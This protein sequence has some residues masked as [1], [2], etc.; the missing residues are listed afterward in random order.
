MYLSL[1]KPPA[2]IPTFSK[3]LFQMQTFHPESVKVFYDVKGHQ[4]VAV[5]EFRNTIEGFKDAEAFENS[6]YYKRRGR[7]DFQKDYPNRCGTHLYGWMATKQV[8]VF[9]RTIHFFIDYMV[10]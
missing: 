6:F 8:Q 3:S 1:S 10:P 4:G 7:K 5:I 2:L 9:F